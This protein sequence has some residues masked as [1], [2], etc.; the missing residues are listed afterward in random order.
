MQSNNKSQEQSFIPVV[1]LTTV[2]VT[3]ALTA[4]T[5][6]GWTSRTPPTVLIGTVRKIVPGC[7]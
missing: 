1:L 2:V 3:V 7:P 6:I 5:V 4:D